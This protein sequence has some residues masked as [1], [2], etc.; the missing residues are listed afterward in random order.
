[1]LD[2]GCGDGAFVKSNPDSYFVDGYDV[3]PYAEYNN[4]R[5]Y[6]EWWDGVTLWDVMEH[7]FRPDWF[8]RDLKSKYVFITTP[9]F[10]SW[11]KNALLGWKHY[12]PK[13][14]QHY[15]NASSLL[16]AMARAGY[17]PVETNFNEGRLRDP[18]HEY[19]IITIVG[20]RDHGY[21]S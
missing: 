6:R 9:H 1:M 8:L 15:F 10:D 17:K 13:E 11:S 7:M 3:N 21:C 14:H 20:R 12:K 5:L 19:N 18:E 16:W 2:W 4:G